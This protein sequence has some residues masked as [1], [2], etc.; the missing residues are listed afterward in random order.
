MKIMDEKGKLFGKLNI[1]DLLAIVII[2]AAL[3]FAALKLFG[4][5]DA[6]PSGSTKLTYTVLVGAV[7]ES[8]KES[9][10]ALMAETENH[11]QLMA[12]GELV[13]GYVT[14][15]TATP[16]VNYSF[17]QNG[18][19]VRSEEDFEGGRWD[20]LFTVETQVDSTVKNEVGTQEVRVGKGHILKTTHLE[21]PYGTILS[22][23]WG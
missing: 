14:G 4:S 19:P 5:G 12:N 9:V 11:D 21:F 7:D 10:E 15:L 13:E 8:T 20:L 18:Q 6:L 3:L 23:T 2:L 22:C 1:I 17:D 16:H